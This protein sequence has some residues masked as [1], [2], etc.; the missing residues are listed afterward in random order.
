MNRVTHKHVEKACERYNAKLGFTDWNRIGRLQWADIRGDGSNRR[1]LYA[2]VNENGGV[3]AS[4]LRGKTMRETIAAIDFAIL[5]NGLPSYAVIIRAIHERGIMQRAALAEL[6]RRGLWL[7]DA[8][9]M[10]AGLI[11]A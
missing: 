5:L 2:V 11:N 9:K 1:S 8:Q 7:S 6:N 3:C 4:H 10:Q